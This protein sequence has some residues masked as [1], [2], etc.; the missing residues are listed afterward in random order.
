MIII[1]LWIKSSLTYETLQMDS[2]KFGLESF[3]C[4]ETLRNF[5]L[6]K[7]PRK[8]LDCRSSCSAVG[9]TKFGLLSS[10]L[11]QTLQENT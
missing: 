5:N 6:I 1:V 4:E 3:K 8:F 2:L 7:T 10:N 9:E 11:L